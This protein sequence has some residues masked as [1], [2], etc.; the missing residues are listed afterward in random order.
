MD[1]EA[2]VHVYNGIL[3][4]HKRE[5][6]WVSSNEVNEPRA[7]YTEWSK[8]E[9][10]REISYINTYIR[11]QEDF[12]VTQMIKNLSAMQETQVQSL[13]PEDPLEK[14]MAILCNI[15]T[16]WIPRT[17]KPG[18]LQSVGSKELDTTEWITLRLWILERWYWWTYLQ[19]SS[20]NA[21]IGNR[22]VDTVRGR[23]GWGELFPWQGSMETCTFPYGK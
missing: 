10:E 11:N 15:L 4:S 21:V 18:E 5:H 19:G 14:G 7:F 23:R 20:G 3:L 9:I 6:I 16:W 1:K 12:P 8:S 17:E 13:H 2:V 22:L